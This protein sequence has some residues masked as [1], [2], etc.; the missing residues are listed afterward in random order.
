M[1]IDLTENEMAK[2]HTRHMVGGRNHSLSNEWVYRIQFP[3]RP[4]ALREFLDQLS[5]K[6]NITLFHYR[7]HGA[8]YG[9]VLA[10]FDI[11]AEDAEALETC[12]RKLGF[13]YI[14]ET[15]NPAYHLFL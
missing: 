7:N 4:G 10:G 9:R 8:D 12:L 5:E 13:K 3:E 14:E 6:W 15:A 11:Q 1:T 2:V